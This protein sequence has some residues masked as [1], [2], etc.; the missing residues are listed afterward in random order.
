MTARLLK[1]ADLVSVVVDEE[2]GRDV[3]PAETVKSDRAEFDLVDRALVCGKHDGVEQLME[4]IAI[5]D[6]VEEVGIHWPNLWK[7]SSASPLVPLTIVVTKLG[8]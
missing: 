6:Q 7:Q 1:S 2:G 3:P 5:S 8:E 4:C